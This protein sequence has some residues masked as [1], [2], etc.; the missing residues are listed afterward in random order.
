MTHLRLG[1]A[2]NF[3]VFQYEVLSK[4]DEKAAYVARLAEQ[5]ERFDEMFVKK[6]LYEPVGEYLRGELMDSLELQHPGP[7]STGR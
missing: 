7:P 6:Q 5:A 2:L 3:S 4:P 1:L